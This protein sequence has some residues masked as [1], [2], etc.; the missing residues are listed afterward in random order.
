MKFL[1]YGAGSIGRGFIGPMYS[2]AGYEV[3][4]VDIDKRIV[5]ALSQKRAYRCAIAAEPSYDIEVAGVRGVD[6][7]DEQAVICEI[8]E[9]DDM[10]VSLGAAVL[11]KVSPLISKGLLKRFKGSGR[12]LNII[13]C[14]NLKDS[15]KLLRGWLEASASDGEK[16]LISEKLGL[17]EA[18]VG[19]MVPAAAPDEGDP[20]RI[21]AEEYGFLPVNRDA[22]LGDAPS[23]EGLIPY[24][25]FAY[26]E[27]R[28][29]YLHNMGHAVCAYLGARHGFGTIAEAIASPAVRL[30]VQS[31]MTESAAMLSAK[32]SI[33]FARVFDHAED[34]LLRFCNAALGD[35]CER[36]ARDPMRKL[37]R[38]DR[39]A[40][41]ICECLEYGVYPVHIALGYAAALHS[42]TDDRTHAAEVAKETGGLSR[43]LVELVTKLFDACALGG[44]EMLLAAQKAKKEMRGSVV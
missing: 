38:G 32:H 2:K 36:V 26:Y 43:E 35:T 11:Q 30:F 44:P 5:H 37:A 14:E 27:D 7:S 19:R 25:P 4:F 8:A 39:L 1:M 29:L 16:Q 20:L 18:A 34:L 15:A 3:V 23:V 31:A 42:V 28:K 33:P 40:G 22:F 24:S 6:A 21:T 12:P 17:V 9:C 13:V 41:A 10:A